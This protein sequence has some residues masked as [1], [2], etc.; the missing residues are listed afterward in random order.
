MNIKPTVEKRGVMFKSGETF[1]AAR[2]FA[3]L[4]PTRRS[5]EGFALQSDR[6]PVE[7]ETLVAR[8]RK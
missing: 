6:T 1:A 5:S 2:L 3:G 7:S 4:S 8:A